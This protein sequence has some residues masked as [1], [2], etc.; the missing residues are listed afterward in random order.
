MPEEAI[1]DIYIGQKSQIMHEE[2]LENGTRL[3]R[4]EELTINPALKQI[5]EA[6]SSFTDSKNIC[7]IFSR[8]QLT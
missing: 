6:T 7:S 5:L 3:R 2:M 1:Y 8:P 4:K